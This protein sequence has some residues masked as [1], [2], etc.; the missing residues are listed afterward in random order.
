M[1][2]RQLNESLTNEFINTQPYCTQ[3]GQ[4]LYTILAFLNAIGLKHISIYSAYPLF[5]EFYL[6]DKAW[7]KLLKFLKCKVFSSAFLAF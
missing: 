1:C 7:T 6:N 2:T 5:F 4:N 3:K